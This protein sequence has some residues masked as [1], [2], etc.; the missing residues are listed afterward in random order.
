[1]ATVKTQIQPQE[2]Q[3]APAA[4]TSE[5]KYWSNG[6][7]VR[8]SFGMVKRYLVN[9]GGNVTDQEV[10]MFLN[11]C[12]FQ[13]L[14]PFLRECYLIKY[15]NYDA[16][17]VVSKEVFIKRAMRN[18]A[19]NGMVGGIIVHDQNGDI[20]ERE[21]S[22]YLDD[23]EKLVGGWCKVYLKNIDWPIYKS[24]RLQDYEGRKNDGTPNTMWASKGATMIAKVAQMQAL[25]EAFPEDLAGM[26]AQEEIIE[27]QD[28]V[29]DEAAVSVSE[30]Q[31]EPIPE[32][33]AA[34]EEKKITT[35]DAAEALFGE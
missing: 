14:N 16:S 13:H 31:A 6:E 19:F 2:Q 11:L 17:I 22:F 8:L 4:T 32:Q 21:G 25:R 27:A 23:Q 5:F 24:V 34:N 28:I 7:E 30:E 18:P 12:R 26:Y 33:P 3:T 1:M 29:L 10:I 15:G 9:G 20:R 35:N